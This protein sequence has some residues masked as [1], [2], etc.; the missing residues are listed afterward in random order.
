MLPGLRSLCDDGDWEKLAAS[1]T[2]HAPMVPGTAPGRP[3]EISK[4]DDL[5][6]LVL[7]YEETIRALDVRGAPVIGQSFGGMLARELAAH[8][9]S[10]FSKLVLLDPIGVGLDGFPGAISRPTTPNGC[11]RGAAVAWPRIATCARPGS[12]VTL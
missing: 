7:V 9:P 5:W 1:Y 8:V 12:V 2:I 10:L 3:D 4:V 6:D 11:A